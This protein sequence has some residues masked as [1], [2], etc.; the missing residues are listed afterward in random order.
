MSSEAEVTALS[1][2]DGD[3]RVQVRW[4]HWL[5]SFF[6]GL[7]IGWVSWR[8]RVSLMKD[9]PTLTPWVLA[10]GLVNLLPLEGWHAHMVPDVPIANAAAL[11]LPPVHAAVVGLLS[12]FDPKEFRRRIS[13]REAIFNRVQF[14]LVYGSGSLVVH[15]LAARPTLPPSI[16]PLA[17]LSVFVSSV[18]NYALVG[19]GLSLEHNEP[20][21]MVIRRMRLGTTTDFALTLAA[22]GVFAAMLAALYTDIGPWALLAFIGP[23]LLGRQTLQRSET[24]LQAHKA[25]ESRG[26]ALQVL[27]NRVHDERR[28][29]RHLIA[30]DLHDEVLQPLYKVT[31]MAQVVKTD[32]STGRLLE[33]DEDVPELLDATEVAASS[34]RQLIGDLRRS[35]VGRGGVVHAL[36]NLVD[37]IQGQTNTRMVADLKSAS[38]SGDE[39]LVIYQVAKEAVQNALKHSRAAQVTLMLED[40]PDGTRLSV[41]DDGEGFDASVRKEGH[42]GLTIMQ[43]RATA[44]HAQLRIQSIRGRGTTVSLTI[45]K[46]RNTNLST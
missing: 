35:A 5:V 24:L 42:F 15:T 43:E 34:L 26:Q 13:M 2:P 30:A 25:Y 23:T 7:L 28:D 32:L 20:F 4:Y 3:T 36:R 22:W 14:A 6:G 17:L 29:E 11:I 21:A 1:T 8:M 46:G 39:E 31:L 45:P 12:A 27:Q 18:T 37:G 40:F 9:L 16:V 38:V 41:Q 33:M 44:V 19:L 10:L